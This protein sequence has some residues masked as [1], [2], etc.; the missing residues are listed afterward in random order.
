MVQR[1]A[2]IIVAWKKCAGDNRRFT[3]GLGIGM[4]CAI[5]LYE[6]GPIFVSMVGI[7]VSNK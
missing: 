3:G 2:T 6:G 7:V 1:I 5:T 4:L